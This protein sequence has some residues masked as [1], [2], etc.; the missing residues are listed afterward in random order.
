MLPLYL[1]TSV[2]TQPILVELKSGETVNGLLENCDSWM[3]LTL[4]DAVTVDLH[5]KRF[6]KV[7]EVYVRGNQIKY[8]RMSNDIIDK[9]KEQN[10]GQ[11]RQRP[12]QKRQQRNGRDRD[13]RER[14]NGNQRIK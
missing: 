3:N 8:V 11:N 12:M 4:N 7:P 10:R 13:P 9:F 14:R 2:K 1:L 5:G 6:E